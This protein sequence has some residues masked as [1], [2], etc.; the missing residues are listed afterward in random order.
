MPECTFRSNKDNKD[1]RTEKSYLKALVCDEAFNDCAGSKQQAALDKALE[2]AAM[3]FSGENR[4]PDEEWLHRQGMR[5]NKDGTMGPRVV[6]SDQKFD[7]LLKESPA[8]K[9]LPSKNKNI[10]H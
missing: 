1:G 2:K 8:V 4:Q 3:S 7:E 5:V 6:F 9:P 10:D